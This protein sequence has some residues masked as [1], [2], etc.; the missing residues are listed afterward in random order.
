MSTPSS[1]NVLLGRGALFFDRYTAAGVRTG[2]RHLGNCDSF[3][4]GIETEKLEMTDYTQ[5]TAANYKEVV[6]KTNVNLTMSGFEFDPNNLSLALLGDQTTYTQSSQTVTGETVL[7]ATATGIAGKYV[8]TAYRDISSVVV[9]QGETTLTL[10][11]DYEITSA[12]AGLIRLLPGGGATDGTAVTVDYSAA[13][14]ST[15]LTVVR[16]ATTAAIEGELFFLPN[17]TTGPNH[18]VRVFRAS[19]APNGELGLISDEFGKWTLEGKALSDAAGAYGGST[20]NP[21]FQL[22]EQAAA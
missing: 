9:K 2:F 21:Y 8:R 15:A 10:N 22:L 18:E 19:L 1:D 17:N 12:A 13:A 7:A 16:G 20:S 11:T 3:A 6:T 14:I 5:Q 4:I